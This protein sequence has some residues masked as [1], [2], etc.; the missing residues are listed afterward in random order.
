MIELSNV[1]VVIVD[2]AAPVSALKTLCHCSKLIK[3]GESL[4]LTSEELKTPDGITLRKIPELDYVGFSRF[5]VNNLNEHIKTEFCLIIHCDGFI[6]NPNLW[7]DEFL[8]YDYIGAP[9]I[10]VEQSRIGNGGFCLRSKRF[11]ELTTNNI[12][13]YENYSHSYPE[14][15]EDHF[16]CRT[17]YSV[18]KNL[19]IKFPP[20]EVACDFSLEAVIPECPR[21]YDNVFGFH[22]K[23]DFTLALMKKIQDNP[24]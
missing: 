20:L 5:M 8:K 19:G 2:T 10:G 17:K 11:L 23:N 12:K 1:T 3:F 7:R 6:L 16:L 9:W 15:N 22:G 21:N 18:L 14:R 13:D 4:I 24:L